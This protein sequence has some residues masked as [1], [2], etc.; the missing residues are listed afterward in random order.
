VKG[1]RPAHLRLCR[2]NECQSKAE[3]R[4]AIEIL[5]ARLYADREAEAERA[6]S[7]ILAMLQKP[8]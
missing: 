6:V 8:K 3:I 4:R 1:E 2:P 5:Q 7:E